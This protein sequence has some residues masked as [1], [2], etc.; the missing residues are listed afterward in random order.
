M[1]FLSFILGSFFTFG[2][3]GSIWGALVVGGF[4]TY[5]VWLLTDPRFRK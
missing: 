2:L 1:Y 3:S 4:T 5:V